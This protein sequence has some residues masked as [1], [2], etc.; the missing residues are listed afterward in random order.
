VVEVMEQ[1]FARS[2]RLIVV[3]G[4]KLTRVGVQHRAHF[5]TEEPRR[6]LRSSIHGGLELAL[7]IKILQSLGS[8]L[9]TRQ[10]S[11]V[12]NR[13]NGTIPLCVYKPGREVEV[14]RNP[15]FCAYR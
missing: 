2:C 9:W 3:H 8:V 14:I 1:H 4:T 10:F 13:L 6:R 5:V 12:V 11:G 15:G 7:R